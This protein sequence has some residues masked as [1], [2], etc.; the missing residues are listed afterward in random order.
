MCVLFCHSFAGPNE[1]MSLKQ[2]KEWHNIPFNF[3][4]TIPCNVKDFTGDYNLTRIFNFRLLCALAIVCLLAWTFVSAPAV[5][6]GISNGNEAHH[7]KSDDI[8]IIADTKNKEFLGK[9]QNLK[10]S[11]INANPGSRVYTCGCYEVFYT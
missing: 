2:S 1:K 3:W 10:G 11:F 4:L 6:N 8:F 9:H 7:V 5:G